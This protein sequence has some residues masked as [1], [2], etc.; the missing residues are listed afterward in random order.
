LFNSVW[1]G[2]TF[3]EQVVVI[4]IGHFLQQKTMICDVWLLYSDH[5]ITGHW[6]LCT[7]DT[8]YHQHH[9]II[10]PQTQ[11]NSTLIQYVH[12]YISTVALRPSTQTSK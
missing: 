1:S 4:F 2:L 11:Y 7:A 6:L 12:T 9:R 10:W 5:I 8:S 3:K